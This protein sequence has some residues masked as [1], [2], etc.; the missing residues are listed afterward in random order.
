MTAGT[1]MWMSTR[2]WNQW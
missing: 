2:Y 1:R